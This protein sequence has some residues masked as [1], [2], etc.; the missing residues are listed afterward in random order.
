MN[1]PM[2]AGNANA[3]R[4]NGLTSQ[5]QVVHV[6]RDGTFVWRS[7]P[8]HDGR[9]VV[10]SSDLILEAQDFWDVV[11]LTVLELFSAPLQLGYLLDEAV[12]LRWLEQESIKPHRFP[13][14]D[15][16]VS[17]IT[18]FLLPTF[19]FAGFLDG[20]PHS[21]HTV[22]VD[23]KRLRRFLLANY[24]ESLS[25]RSTRSGFYAGQGLAPP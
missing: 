23:G 3:G 10:A 18:E 24:S 7:R 15:A 6:R 12:L 16:T 8:E 20:P 21:N 2:A 13:I 22:R 9:L 5:N 19:P 25:P 11:P 14:V 17:V 4:L 1:R